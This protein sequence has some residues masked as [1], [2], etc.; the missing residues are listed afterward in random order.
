MTIVWARGT[1]RSAKWVER[2]NLWRTRAARSG[3][4]LAA[5][6][7]E[8]KAYPRQSKKDQDWEN[9]IWNVRCKKRLR[10]NQKTLF[11]WNLD[12]CESTDQIHYKA[13]KLLS[14]TEVWLTCKRFVKAYNAVAFK[15]LVLTQRWLVVSGV[16]GELIGLIYKSQTLLG[17]DRLCPKVGN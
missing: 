16:S 9:I 11:W 2:L 6:R 13:V 10:H 15:V 14:K 17:N 3:R 4:P 5:T 7:V 8:V 1:I 12:I